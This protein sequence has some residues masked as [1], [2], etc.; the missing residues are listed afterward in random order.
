MKRNYFKRIA[1]FFLLFVL[2]IS[3]FALIGCEGCK[4]CNDPD[5]NPPEEQ[6]ELQLNHSELNTL[7]GDENYLK[8]TNKNVDKATLTWE[9]SDPDCVQVDETGKVVSYKI[10][11]AT[12]TAKIGDMKGICKVTVGI[13]NTLPLL[14]L[15]NEKD[16]Y[17]ISKDYQEYPFTAYVLYNGKKFYDVEVEWKSA[18]ENVV[19]F[20]D[21]TKSSLS[22]IEK[23]STEIILNAKWRGLTL[24][25]APSLYKTIAVEVHDDVYFFINGEQVN[26]IN[27]YTVDRFAGMDYDG[28][29]ENFIPTAQIKGTEYNNSSAF[30]IS[31]TDNL[32]DIDANKALVPNKYGTG[33][34]DIS[35]TDNGTTYSF[36][37]KLNIERPVAEY[38]GRIDYFSAKTGLVKDLV[39]V[40]NNTY[41]NKTMVQKAFE[42]EIFY[43][44][45]NGIADIKVYQGENQ[46]NYDAETGKVNGIKYEKDKFYSENFKIETSKAVYI[47][48]TDIYYLVL[49]DKDDLALLKQE[50]VQDKYGKNSVTNIDGYCVLASNIDAENTGIAHDETFN[51]TGS[52]RWAYDFTEK[53]FVECQDGYGAYGFTGRFNGQGYSI[54]N[55]KPNSRG[56]LGHVFFGAIVEN[57]GFYNLQLDG[58]SGLIY[59]NFGQGG[60]CYQYDPDG[61]YMGEAKVKNVYAHLSTDTENPQ[62]AIINKPIVPTL[63][64]LFNFENIIVDASEVETANSAGSAFVNNAASFIYSGNGYSPKKDN[65]LISDKFAIAAEGTNKVYGGNEANGQALNTNH[66]GTIYTRGIDRYANYA[67][68]Q[69]SG[70]DF[71]SFKTDNGWLDIGYPIFE[72][73]SLF[74]KAQYN[75]AWVMNDTIYINSAVES[76]VLK[77][78]VPAT[79]QVVGSTEIITAN[80]SSELNIVDNND[81]TFNVKLNSA[82]SSEQEYQIALKAN[83]GELGEKTIIIKVMAHPSE[84]VVNDPVQMSVVD[85]ILDLSKFDLPENTN[86]KP[87]IISASQVLGSG[88]QPLA[89]TNGKITNAIC[90]ILADNSDVKTAE[91]I[92]S[93]NQMTYRFTN[94]KIYSHLIDEADDLKIFALTANSG[95]I[96]GYYKMTRTIDATGLVIGHDAAAIGDDQ[97]AN[98]RVGFQ[99]IFDGDGYEIYNFSPT[100]YGLFGAIYSNNDAKAVIRN[101][102]FTEVK[103]TSANNFAILSRY[104]WADGSASALVENAN[105]TISNVYL[106]SAY[107]TEI[108]FK[109][110]FASNGVKKY[111]DPNND[112]DSTINV[113]KLKNIYI[114]ILEDNITRILMSDSEGLNYGTIISRELGISLA[115]AEDRAQRFENVLTVAKIG[116]CVYR[117]S[118][119]VDTNGDGNNDTWELAKT[120][121][122]IHMYFGYAENDIGSDGIKCVWVSEN[123]GYPH[124]AVLANGVSDA[125]RK[126]AGAYI[127]NNVY[128][129]DSVDSL[130]T[131]ALAKVEALVGTGRW[132]IKDGKPIWKSNYYTPDSPNGEGEFKPEGIL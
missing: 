24:T 84:L 124:K 35:I 114:E 61:F 75:G 5:D 66:G 109:G 31:T 26:D 15:D 40:E 81:G 129:Y 29:F 38:D 70:K 71:S 125:D 96:R 42:N 20:A 85:G 1:I 56:L 47:I 23:G 94:V 90:E 53:S 91:L 12:I 49:S 33:T 103:S 28:K 6:Y 127:Y 59:S 113:F 111:D 101:V 104:I 25:E 62:G 74:G 44:N 37:I 119:P 39:D 82:V 92:I 106:N 105:F 32:A 126:A 112:I 87:V 60:I 18:D 130:M 27:L 86:Y 54:D 99:G 93:T 97:C 45:G 110:L 34:V 107:K 69:A 79:N 118:I 132:E 3:S 55:F 100:I 108:N 116:P 8:V 16:K 10:G 73:A 41:A 89:V 22:I 88:T 78:V 120:F 64:G 117:K 122:G 128:R 9:S 48:T 63:S 30:S 4:G 72:S 115:S 67:D 131:T 43:D 68:L 80:T 76:K 102:S 121:D 14:K 11:E 46:V 95:K 2:M 36:A 7:I 98:A 123:D 65:Y 13:G 52:Y 58:T 50:L 51:P 19:K 77:L 83:Y 21:A 17:N 57:L